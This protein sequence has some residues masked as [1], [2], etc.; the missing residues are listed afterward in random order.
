MDKNLKWFE[1]MP[2]EI[3]LGYIKL[4]IET[5]SKSD[6]E[7][8]GCGGRCEVWEERISISPELTQ[9]QTAHVLLHE[10]I[11]AAFDL[12]YAGSNEFTKEDLEKWVEPFVT[13]T[14]RGLATIIADNPGVMP[15]IQETLRGEN[16]SNVD[17]R[18]QKMD[19]KISYT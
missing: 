14:A 6:A 16:P 12:F 3:K 18:T 5:M 1:D 15:W 19:T 17:N 7:Y 13:G 9:R 8:N 11:H 10:L 4:A 2:K